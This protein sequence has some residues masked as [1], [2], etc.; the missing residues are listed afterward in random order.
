MLGSLGW[1]ELLIILVIIALLFGASRVGDMG[2][3]LGRGVKEFRSEATAKDEP[4]PADA[5]PP[6]AAS[7]STASTPSTVPGEEPKSS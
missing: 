3:A 5:A 7:A 1:Q 4:K 2:K 6:P